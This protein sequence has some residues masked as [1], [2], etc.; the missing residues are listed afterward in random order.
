MKEIDF[1]IEGPYGKRIWIMYLVGVPFFL[2]AIV[3]GLALAEIHWGYFLASVLIS[4]IV[5]RIVYISNFN[6]LCFKFKGF[7]TWTFLR[8]MA[9]YETILVVIWYGAFKLIYLVYD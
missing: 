6:K 7:P 3:F 5:F 2:F 9:I 8:K 4:E 1:Q